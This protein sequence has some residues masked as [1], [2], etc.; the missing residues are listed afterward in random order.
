MATRSAIVMHNGHHQNYR[1]IYC[2]WDGYPEHNGVVLLEHYTNPDKV[3]EL[4][5]LGNLSSLGP[6][7]GEKHDFDA[8]DESVC[9]FYGRDRGEEEQEA[10]AF[11][12]LNEVFNHYYAAGC[13]YL[14][15]FHP[16]DYEDWACYTVTGR[17]YINLYKIREQEKENA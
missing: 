5:S 11:D 15:V 3:S 2:H 4:I 7:I 14:Y 9:T 16:N 12:T 17:D 1:S 8:R 6:D 13:D 10:K